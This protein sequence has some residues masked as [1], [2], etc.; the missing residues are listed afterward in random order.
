MS[1]PQH[2]TATDCI[3]KSAETERNKFHFIHDHAD[4]VCE[5]YT[6]SAYVSGNLHQTCQNTWLFGNFSK[7]FMPRTKRRVK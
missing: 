2:S 1:E 6:I 7:D 3:K 5:I 4:N